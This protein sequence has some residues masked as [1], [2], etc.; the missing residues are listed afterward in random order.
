MPEPEW[1]S[2][3]EQETWR[4]LVV[5]MQMLQQGLDR[6]LQRDADMP[7]AYYAILVHLSEAPERTL[8]MSDLATAL[9][10][11]PSRLSHAV[12]RMESGGWVARRPCDADRRV[13]FASITDGGMAALAAAAPGHVAFVREHVFSG[14]DGAQQHAL[15]DACLRI[16]ASLTAAL[17]PPSEPGTA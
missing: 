12:S 11:S 9:D 1:L 13:T 3:D 5:L 16:N 8:R 17:E 14:L 7:H 6:Q 10:Y 15:R 4:S 2:D